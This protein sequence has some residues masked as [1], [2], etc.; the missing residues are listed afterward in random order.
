MLN[1]FRDFLEREFGRSTADARHTIEVATAALLLEVSRMDG[2][3]DAAE[4]DAVQR[5]VRDKFGL[6]EDAAS[7]LVALAEEQARQAT[8]YYQFTSVVNERFDYDR[9]VRI[10]ELLWEIAYADGEMSPYE[11]HLIRKLADLLYVSHGDYIHA[12]LRARDAVR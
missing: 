5:A 10:V 2:G 6:A 1:R 3:V 4:R 11:E 8:D 7:E 9:K 12:K